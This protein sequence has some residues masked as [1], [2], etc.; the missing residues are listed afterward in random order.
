[1]I[2]VTV[3]VAKAF[4]ASISNFLPNFTAGFKLVAFAIV[5]PIFVPID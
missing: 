4:S 3:A 1:M 5:V 2:E